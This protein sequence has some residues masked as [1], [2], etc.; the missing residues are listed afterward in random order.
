MPKATKRPVYRHSEFAWAIYWEFHCLGDMT[1]KLNEQLNQIVR[2]EGEK[3]RALSAESR[4]IRTRFVAWRT[5]DTFPRLLNYSIITMAGGVTESSAYKICA[6]LAKTKKSKVT[7]KDFAG[8][9]IDRALNYLSKIHGLDR[10]RVHNLAAIEQ[11]QV[12]RNVIVHSNGFVESSKDPERIRKL[13]SETFVW[14]NWH[15]ESQRSYALG[16][17]L[18]LSESQQGDRLFVHRNLAHIACAVGREFISSIMLQLGFAALSEEM[19]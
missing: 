14:R 18:K 9:G 16:E 15:D 1:W 13:R 5:D 7:V 10:S 19:I 2:E 3:R 4:G 17:M 11:L 12:I 8:Q 6:E